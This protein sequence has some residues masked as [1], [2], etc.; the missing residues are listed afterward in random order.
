MFFTGREPNDPAGSLQTE[1]AIVNGTGSQIGG[2]NRWGDY[3]AL[4]VDP[5]DDCTFWYT[6][7]Y[8]RTTGSFNWNTRIANFKFANCGGSNAAAV[9]LSATKLAFGKRVLRTT[10]AA[11]VVRL[12]NTG[13]STLNISSITINGDFAISSKTCG[14]TLAAGNS[15]TVSVTF[16]PT[17]IG[18][19]TGILTFND[20]A[21]NNPQTVA[22][23]GT[24]TQLSLSPTSLNFGTMAVG[25]T[26]CGQVGHIHE[27]GCYA[28]DV[29]R[30]L[31]CGD[32]SRGLPD[33]ANTCG[34]SLAAG[35]S[36]AV[37]V[38][39]KPTATGTRKAN[40]ESG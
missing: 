23:T 36:C 6:Q 20:D 5:V 26:K 39:F 32:Q 22:L 18:V 29:H 17:V 4:T 1:T 7:E 24:G 37:S 16:T 25:T 38:R 19:R 12:T 14:T 21:P 27:R 30:D 13:T 9:A 40:W 2:L 10:S 8:I 11:K 34:T 15:C 28:G 31:H 3:S 35:G 33:S